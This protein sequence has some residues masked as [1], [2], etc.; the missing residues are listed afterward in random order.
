MPQKQKSLHF[1]AAQIEV[2]IFETDRFR[3]IGII[4]DHKRGRLGL[5]QDFHGIDEHL[6][7]SGRQVG[8][9]RLSRPRHDVAAHRDDALAPERMG[10]LMHC[11]ISLCIEHDLRETCSVPQ[12]DKHDHPM[13]TTPLDPSIEHHRLTDMRLV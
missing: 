2:S 4:F 13:V 6:D 9:S 11:R 1:G 7:I 10:S 8:I 3:D 5:V 12:I